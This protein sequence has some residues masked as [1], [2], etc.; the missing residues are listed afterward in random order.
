MN[1]DG[2][3]DDTRE[4]ASDAALRAEAALVKVFGVL[5]GMSMGAFPCWTIPARASFSVAA[6]FEVTHESTIWT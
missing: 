5:D 6:A 1:L 3:D 2:L 4:S